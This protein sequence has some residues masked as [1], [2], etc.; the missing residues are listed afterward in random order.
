MRAD[1]EADK[2]PCDC[3]GW[4]SAELIKVPN[5]AQPPWY[6]CADCIVMDA[7]GAAVTADLAA[8]EG[9]TDGY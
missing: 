9:G 8:I 4:W 3:C 2:D 1:K 5:G 6:V 7:T